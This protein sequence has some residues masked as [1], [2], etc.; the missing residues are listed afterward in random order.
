VGAAI[1]TAG[2]G[3]PGDRL[4]YVP[5]VKYSVGGELT[6]PLAGQ[7]HGYLRPEWQHVGEEATQFG[8][9]N[10]ASTMPAYNNLN[11]SAGVR[12]DVFDI[13]L[14]A[15]NLTNSV[16]IINIDAPV[17]DDPVNLENRP[18]TVGINFR[19]MQ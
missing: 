19:Y 16:Q 12:N 4:S 10:Y 15:H 18:L 9:T 5:R 7:W 1:L 17:F 13:S 6:A 11:L 2:V 8:V 14:Y 3:N